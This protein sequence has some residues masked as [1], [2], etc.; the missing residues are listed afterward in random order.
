MGLINWFCRCIPGLS[1][2]AWASIAFLALGDRLA[3]WPRVSSSNGAFP[4]NGRQGGGGGLHHLTYLQLA[5]ICYSVLAHLLACLG[6][7][8]RLCWAVWHITGEVKQAEFE[9]AEGD[10]DAESDSESENSL[11]LSAGFK[12]VSTPDNPLS[13]VGTPKVP[14]VH[15]GKEDIKEVVIHAIILPSYKEDIDTLRETLAVLASHRL[16]HLSYDVGSARTCHLHRKLRWPVLFWSLT[17]CSYRNVGLSC[18][19]TTRSGR[20]DYRHCTHRYI[21]RFLSQHLLYPTSR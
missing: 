20:C 16:A 2:I 12:D 19:G 13:R 21:C 9:A 8:L 6:F 11:P 10:W 15:D 3:F 14:S 1:I 5:Y 4:P 7:P 18:H 17:N